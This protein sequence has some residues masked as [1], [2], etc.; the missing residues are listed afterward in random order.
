MTD[1]FITAAVA[2]T[3]GLSVYTQAESVALPMPMSVLTAILGMLAAGLVTWGV[4]KKATERNETEISLLRNTL[5]RNLE[6]LA[7]VRERVARIEG[8]C[9]AKNCGTDW[10]PFGHS[11]SHPAPIPPTTR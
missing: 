10:T 11:S 9:V 7:E 5:D 4:F 3:T 6:L 1:N 2:A 8:T